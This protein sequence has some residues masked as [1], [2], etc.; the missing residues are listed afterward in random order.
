MRQR[1][2]QQ[3]RP[4]KR[5]DVQSVGTGEVKDELIMKKIRG[6]RGCCPVCVPVC[7]RGNMPTAPT[8]GAPGHRHRHAHCPALSEHW[9]ARVRNQYL[10]EN[11][12]R[13]EEVWQACGVC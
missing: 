4:V 3:G 13:R 10:P 2:L 12:A 1:R 5:R 6:A 7:E 11:E 8:T 9:E